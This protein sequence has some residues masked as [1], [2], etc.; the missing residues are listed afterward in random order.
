VAT[1]PLSV[2]S[3]QQ[4]IEKTLGFKEYAGNYSRQL[5]LLDHSGLP[6]DTVLRQLDLLG[7]V[8]AELRSFEMVAA[9]PPQEPSE[10]TL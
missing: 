3:P 6:L 2:G 8:V 1:T 7:E 5:F 9:Q 10:V 4:V